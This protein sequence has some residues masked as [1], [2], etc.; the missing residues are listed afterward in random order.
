MK[1]RIVYLVW[2][3]TLSPVLES[4]I[5]RPASCLP[6]YMDAE[7]LA[8]TPIGQLL[9]SPLR[10]R[11][12]NVVEVSRKYGPNVRIVLGGPTRARHAWAALEKWSLFRALRAALAGSSEVVIHAR[13]SEATIWALRFKE[14]TRS[15]VRVVF[16][17][18]GDEPAEAVASVG[19]DPARPENWSDALRHLGAE[20]MD[21]EAKACSADAIICVSEALASR[22]IE[23]QRVKRSKITVIPSCVD[24]KR[25]LDGSRE[26]ARRRFGLTDRFVVAYL[27]SLEWYQLPHECLRVFKLIK[28]VRKDAHFLAITT[29]PERMKAVANANGLGPEEHTIISLPAHEVPFALKA[30]DV[31]LLLRAPDPVNKVASPV[32]FAEYLAA[33]LPVLLTPGIGDYSELLVRRNLGVCLS[34][35]PTDEESISRLAPLL[36]ASGELAAARRRA[37]VEFVTAELSW[38]SAMNRLATPNAYAGLQIADSTQSPESLT[39][40]ASIALS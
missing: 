5:I 31:G 13:G 37:C 38:Q 6:G 33:G 40:M 21:R 36:F 19:G 17:C 23:R 26:E 12:R 22:L 35:E 1:T 20:A 32:K 25:F 8:I 29:H 15:S 14:E 39:R 27:G 24:S 28:S 2:R 34:S 7:I 4:Q 16:D 11:V 3:E 18:R 9:R 10:Q 30:G